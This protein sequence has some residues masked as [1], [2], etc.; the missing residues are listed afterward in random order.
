MPASRVFDIAN[1]AHLG[2]K[3]LPKHKQFDQERATY[4]RSA[5]DASSSFF[6]TISFAPCL[7]SLCPSAHSANTSVDVRV[8]AV[9]VGPRRLL[10]RLRDITATVSCR[11]LHRHLLDHIRCNGLRPTPLADRSVPVLVPVRLHSKRLHSKCM[12]IC[13]PCF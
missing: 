4:A 11:A 7:P 5:C 12:W 3:R 6:L 2:G 9:P 1:K 10:R 8:R 13:L